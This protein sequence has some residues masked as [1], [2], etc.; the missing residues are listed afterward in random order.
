MGNGPG[1]SQEKKKQRAAQKMKMGVEEEWKIS[2]LFPN[3]AILEVWKW[4]FCSV[5]LNIN[6]GG[7]K[8]WRREREN[9]GNVASVS[10]GTVPVGD[11]SH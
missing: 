6:F 3:N 2:D 7:G 4:I 8:R 10:F 1:F 5:Y 11:S 9:L